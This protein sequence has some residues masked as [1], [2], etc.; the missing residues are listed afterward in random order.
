MSEM[1]NSSL[2][3]M[4]LINNVFRL[5]RMSLSKGKKVGPYEIIDLLKEGS[6]SKIYLAK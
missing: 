5:S 6:S 2:K 3:K 1:L 4:K